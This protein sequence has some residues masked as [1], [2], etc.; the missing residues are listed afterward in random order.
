MSHEPDNVLQGEDVSCANF[1]PLGDSGKWMLLCISHSHGCRY[2]LGEWDT[3]C[4]QFVPESHHRM[5]WHPAGVPPHR[6]K[7]PH[8]ALQHTDFFAPES[9][10]IEDG[11]R[12]MWAWL[13]TLDLALQGKTIQS[14]PRELSLGDDGKLR[15]A[16]LRELA[17]LRDKAPKCLKRWPLIRF[18]SK[19][20]VITSNGS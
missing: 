13:P 10:L 4:E 2:Y 8:F 20:G 18:P 9:L 7:P 12:V 19:P 3:E 1:F 15:I 5:N 6:G 14:L 11:R 16:P 17:S